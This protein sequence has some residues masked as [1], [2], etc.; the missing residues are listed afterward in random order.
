MRLSAG[1]GTDFWTL[2]DNISSLPVAWLSLQGKRISN[3]NVEL[4]WHVGNEKQVHHYELWRQHDMQQAPERVGEQIARGDS[5][6]EHFDFNPH[7][8][9]SYYQVRAIDVDGSESRSEL[10]TIDGSSATTLWKVYPNPAKNVVHIEGSS[11]AVDAKLFDAKGSM[12]FHKTFKAGTHE[13][14]IPVNQFAEGLYSLILTR[15]NEKPSI[16]LLMI[17]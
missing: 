13:K 15:N 11:S 5:V 6:Y 4:Q 10:I 2:S 16:H 12:V 7:R 9:L 8:G 1:G 3:S 14:S 17:E